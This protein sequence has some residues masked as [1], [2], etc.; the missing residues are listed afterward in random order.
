MTQPAEEEEVMPAPLW[1]AFWSSPMAT[2]ACFG[3]MSR[4]VSIDKRVRT[5]APT[6]D[7]F[8]AIPAFRKR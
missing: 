3:E 8:H 4:A 5:G 7:H 2:A 6:R 1:V